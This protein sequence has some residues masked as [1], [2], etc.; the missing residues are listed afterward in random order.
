ML[1]NR[2]RMPS[3]K[4]VHIPTRS[5]GRLVP[6]S[7]TLPTRPRVDHI[8]QSATLDVLE[9]REIRVIKVSLLDKLSSFQWESSFPSGVIRF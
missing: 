4:P 1:S 6:N 3:Y 2:Q 9:P 8:R 7:S 5:Q